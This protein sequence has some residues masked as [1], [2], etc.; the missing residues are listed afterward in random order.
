MDGHSTLIGPVEATARPS[1]RA[2]DSDELC[3][4]RLGRGTRR[5]SRFGAGG[6]HLGLAGRM[7]DSDGEGAADLPARLREL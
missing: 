2:H 7:E 6:R 4:G 1:L 5:A 3:G